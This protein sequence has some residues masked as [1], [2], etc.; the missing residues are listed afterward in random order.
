ML[1]PAQFLSG[2]GSN[3]PSN[4]G[5]LA[6]NYYTQIA[7]YQAVRDKQLHAL[8]LLPVHFNLVYLFTYW[9]GVTSGNIYMAVLQGLGTA[10]VLILNTVSAWKSWETNLPEGYGTYQFFFFGWRTLTPGWRKFILA[11]QIG[12]S[13]F[14]VNGVLITLVLP[15]VAVQRRWERKVE[16][17]F[18]YLAVPAGAALMLFCFWPLILWTELIVQRNHIESETDMVAVWLFVAQ[19]V[20]MIVPSC[21]GWM[22]SGKER[23]GGDRGEDGESLWSTFCAVARGLRRPAMQDGNELQP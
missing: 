3:C 23:T 14:A 7:W 17:W 16:W 18:K 9:G 22:R 8:S 13:L 21:T 12:D 19:C 2:I 1:A 4:L 5:F 20:A 15:V 10:A 11:W 6:Y